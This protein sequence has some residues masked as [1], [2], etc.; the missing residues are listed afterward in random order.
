MYV[1]N[2][3]NPNFGPSTIVR[4]PDS[5]PQLKKSLI[6]SLLFTILTPIWS[7]RQIF[8]EVAY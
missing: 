3:L 6:W 4:T 2:R 5:V 1:K 8:A 7:F